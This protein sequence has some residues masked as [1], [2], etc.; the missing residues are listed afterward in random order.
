MKIL[1]LGGGGHIGSGLQAMLERRADTHITVFSRRPMAV[2]TGVEHLCVDCYN[3]N[4]LTNALAQRQWDVVY[5]MICFNGAQARL[6]AKVFAHKVKHYVMVSSQ[7]VYPAGEGMPEHYFSPDG[8]DPQEDLLARRYPDQAYSIGK[9]SAEVAFYRHASFQITSVRLAPV[10]SFPDQRL[11]SEL[12]KIITTKK[13][14]VQ[15]T[16]AYLSLISLKD[17]IA[18]LYFM[19]DNPIG[20]PINASSDP[21][22]KISE[23]FAVISKAA[24]NNLTLSSVPNQYCWHPYSVHTAWEQNPEISFFSIS[25]SWTMSTDYAKKLGIE[26]SSSPSWIKDIINLNMENILAGENS[27]HY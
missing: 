21:P 1:I 16:A 27:V 15:N 12:S 18:S 26:F 9:R 24:G 5:D 25:Q 11:H 2:N 20:R 19:T 10:V 13:M 17:A 14:L 7:A 6:R 8:A 3:E 23:L 4:A 22:L